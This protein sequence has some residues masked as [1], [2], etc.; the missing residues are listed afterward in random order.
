MH[1]TTLPTLNNVIKMFT[2]HYIVHLRYTFSPINMKVR[3]CDVLVWVQEQR[4]MN[5][6]L[7]TFGLVDFTMLWL[8]LAL[9]AF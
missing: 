4:K 3:G 2:V 8:V 7:G 5:Q 1:S 9:Q 6:V